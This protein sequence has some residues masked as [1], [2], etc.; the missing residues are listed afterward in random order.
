MCLQVIQ[1]KAIRW[2]TNTH[3]PLICDI[4]EQQNIL[5]IEPIKE[6]V[7]RLAHKIWFDIETENSP[8]FETT[9][10]IPI[11]RGHAWFKSSYASTF[12]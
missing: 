9:K 4:N 2:I 1:N 3:Y 6:R 7:L 5:K 8:F 11:L 12:E 10:S